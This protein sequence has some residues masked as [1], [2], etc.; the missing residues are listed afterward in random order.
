M[1]ALNAMTHPSCYL[2][3]AKTF[4]RVGTWAV[5]TWGSLLE[6]EG[7][8]DLAPVSPAGQAL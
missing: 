3:I 1:T 6:A 4:K 7:S 5:D 8:S 2:M